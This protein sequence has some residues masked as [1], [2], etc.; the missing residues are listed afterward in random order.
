MPQLAALVLKDKSQDSF[1]FSPE[2][3]KDGVAT[4]VNS[5]GVPIGEQKLTVAASRTTTG[6]RKVSMRIAIPVVQDVV[7]AGISKPTVVRTAYADCVFTFD[8]TSNEVE[9]GD[10]RALM[11]D[12]LTG[13][14]AVACIE[15]L[16]HLY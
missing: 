1:T 16:E 8:S 6:R 2:G 13:A 4:L 5:T 14:T 15:K 11:A 3:I 12:L 9:R 10:I 7:V